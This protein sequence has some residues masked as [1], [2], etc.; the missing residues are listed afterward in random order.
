MAEI[1]MINSS[2]MIPKGLIVFISGVPGV[3]KTTISY[4]LFKRC[5]EF[6][7]IQ[8]TDLIREIL[9]GYNEYLEAEIDDKSIIEGLSEKVSIPDHMKIFNYM[10]LKEQCLTMKK[11]IEQIIA[12]QQRKGIASIINGVHIVP[13]VLNGIWQNKNIVYINLYINT[14]SALRIRLS[15]RDE[16]KYMPYLDVSFEANCSLYD[17]TFTLS[18]EQPDTFTNIDVTHLTVD[19]VVEKVIR[20][21]NRN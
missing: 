18:Q 20:F 19:Q 16:R 8:E 14:K 15:E 10:E 5:N 2:I 3:G 6:R 7:I 4:E 17:S 13:E 11:S 1:N 21:I 9:R 12:R